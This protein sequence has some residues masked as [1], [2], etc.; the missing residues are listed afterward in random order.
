LARAKFRAR[1][2]EKIDYLHFPDAPVGRGDQG[3]ALF[4]SRLPG[5]TGNRRSSKIACL[6]GNQPAILT[7]IDNPTARLILIKLPAAQGQP[8]SVFVIA[9]HHYRHDIVLSECLDAPIGEL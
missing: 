2:G 3:L 7:E 4:C 6:G 5:Q 9:E 1:A 8:R